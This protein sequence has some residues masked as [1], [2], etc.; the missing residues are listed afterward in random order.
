MFP[1]DFQST[2]DFKLIAPLPSPQTLLPA[3]SPY[4]IFHHPKTHWFLSTNP[5]PRGEPGGLTL[6]HS[7]G[8]A[9]LPESQEFWT[10]PQLPG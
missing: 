1:P 9:R 3:L 8:K 5:P 6:P 2:Y 7:P 4:G 10:V